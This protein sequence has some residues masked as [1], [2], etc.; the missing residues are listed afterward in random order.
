MGDELG[1]A[2]TCV[3]P[4]YAVPELVDDP[5]LAARGL[6]VDATDE[7]NGAFRQLAPLLAGAQPRRRRWWPI[8]RDAPTP[9]RSWPR[10]AWRP[11]ES[12]SCA[13]DGVVA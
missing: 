4:V 13:E 11:T 7:D 10:P 6:I 2:D 5:H 8:R 1:P 12:P 3:G 9:T